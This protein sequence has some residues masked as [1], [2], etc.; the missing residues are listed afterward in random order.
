MLRNY[1][2][3]VVNYDARLDLRIKLASV[4]RQ[5]GFVA[6]EYRFEVDC[7]LRHATGSFSYVAKDLCY[8]AESF[9]RFSWELEQMRRGQNNN[10]TLRSVGEMMVL[11]L[12]GDSRGLQAQ[13][14]I[15]EYLAPTMAR[16]SAALQVDYDLFVN[17][18]QAEVERFA[19]ELKSLETIAEK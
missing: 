13:L 14:E 10:A 7:Q 8:E 15:R 18:L 19:A 16:L 1:P 2:E 4:N 17:K 9:E 11:R 12:E 5:G 3:L 6:T